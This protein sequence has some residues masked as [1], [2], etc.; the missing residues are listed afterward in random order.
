MSER[1]VVQI[2]VYG[3]RSPQARSAMAERLA[4]MGAAA[5]HVAP[6][7]VIGTIPMPG[8]EPDPTEWTGQGLAFVEGRDRAEKKCPE[9]RH[10]IL[11]HTRLLQLPTPRL[12]SVGHEQ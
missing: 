12:W 1:P 11:L 4:S 6:C 3:N 10:A 8:C 5:V 7:W 9:L 2:V